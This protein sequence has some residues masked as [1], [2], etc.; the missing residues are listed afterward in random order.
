[1]LKDTPENLNANV[2]QFREI[3]NQELLRKNFLYK[4]TLVSKRSIQFLPVHV[5]KVEVDV[6]VLDDG[7][8]RC[9]GVMKD[10][11]GNW[12]CGFTCKLIKVP[13]VVSEQIGIIHRLHLC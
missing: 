4:N 9:G 12:L 6:S 10:N 3:A 7:Q 13:P 1:M 2:S 8:S 11:K 5:V